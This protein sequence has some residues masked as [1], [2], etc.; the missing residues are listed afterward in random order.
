MT[1]TFS[2]AAEVTVIVHS[3]LISEL[4]FE[5]TVI[6]AVPAFFAVTRPFSSTVATVSSEDV[7]SQSFTVALS[8]VTVAT[9]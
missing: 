4:S 6:T 1:S 7:H 9:S 3:A 5:V 8:G 2:G